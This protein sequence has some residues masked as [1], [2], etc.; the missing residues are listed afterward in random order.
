MF[1]V[2][3]NDSAESWEFRRETVKLLW[4]DPPFG[5][6]KKMSQGGKSYR[7]WGV[8]VAVR[9]C[10]SAVR[11]VLPLMDDDGVVC[12]CSDYR[13][14]HRMVVGLEDL[15]LTYRGDIVWT[16]GL[17]RPR[18]SWWPVRHNTVATFTVSDT[19]P[20]FDQNAVPRERRLAP[21]KGYPD[22]KAA[23]SVWDFTMSNTDPQR[24]GY[25]N[26]KPAELIKPFVLA[27][28]SEG[29]VVADPFCGS[30]STGVAALSVGR[31]FLGQDNSR[32]AVETA[33][34]NLAASKTGSG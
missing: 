27:H 30:G 16:F 24:V 10:V 1:K 13:S 28:T 7:D 18:T 5:T 6:N 17:G 26:Q 20:P 8:D 2:R 11:N 23:G 31:S 12:I 25:P 22:D 29:D 21:K 14:I 15:G 33:L 9:A 3:C 19:L 32:D 4:T 34:T